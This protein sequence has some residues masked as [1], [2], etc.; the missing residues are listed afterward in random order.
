MQKTIKLQESAE[1]QYEIRRSLA[2]FE[3]KVQQNIEMLFSVPT[4]KQEL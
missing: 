1:M 2:Q 3:A 4:V